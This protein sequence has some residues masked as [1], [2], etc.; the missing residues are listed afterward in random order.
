MLMSENLERALRWAAVCHQGQSR[1]GSGTPYFQHV[2]GVAMILDRVG[3]PEPVVIAGLLHDAVEDTEA[4]LDDVRDRFGPEV[5]RIV[6]CCS[7]VKNDAKGNQRPW[8]ARKEDHLAILAKKETPDEA[9][10]VILADKL[11]NLRSMAC[12]LRDGIDV[13]ASFHADRSM[14]R[15]YYKTTIEICGR[16]TVALERLGEECRSGLAEVEA[17]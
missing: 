7:E 13:W 17:I 5:A 14:V 4:T 9:R 8:I 16:G 15:W 10:A 1:R 11:H 12:D 2:V 6:D 3:F